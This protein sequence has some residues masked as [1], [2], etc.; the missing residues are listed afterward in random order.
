V[1]IGTL[2]QIHE[3]STLSATYTVGNKFA[4]LANV[5]KLR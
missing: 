2:G 4:F 3:S 5:N 1:I